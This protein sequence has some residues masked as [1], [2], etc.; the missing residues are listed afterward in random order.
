MRK[1]LDTLGIDR[2]DLTL[3]H[4]PSPNE[5][6]P[7]GVYMEQIA[8]AQALGLTRL[9]GVSNFT[10]ALLKESDALIGSGKI[11]NN[12]VE[13]NPHLQNRKLA[14]HCAASGIS[15]TC[16]LPIA[17]GRLRGDSVIAPI[18]QRHGAS[19]EQIALAFER[20]KGLIAIPT[21]GRRDR[22]LSNYRSLEIDL[23]PDEITTIEAIDRNDREID[24]GWGPKWD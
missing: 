16:Y 5:R 12:Q 6:V 10:I 24:P 4:W 18:A 9:I 17:R 1:S 2:L 14:A 15:V 7:L 21:S 20:A 3:I 8:E 19:E 13:L 11:A 23:T 22:I